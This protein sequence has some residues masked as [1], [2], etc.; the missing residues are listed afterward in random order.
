M[1]TFSEDVKYIIRKK[2]LDLP[3]SNSNHSKNS[4]RYDTAKITAK[5]FS[6]LSKQQIKDLYK[7]YR[8]DFELFGYDIKDYL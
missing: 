6:Q 5:Y 4:A 1:E 8:M 2:N 7:M 3:L